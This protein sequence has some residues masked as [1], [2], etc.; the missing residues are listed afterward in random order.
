MLD[1]SAVLDEVLAVVA[2]EGLDDLRAS[3]RHAQALAAFAAGD[4]A[5]A[6][7][8]VRAALAMIDALRDESEPFFECVTLGAPILAE[9]RDGRL[10]PVFEDTVLRFRRLPAATATVCGLVNVADRAL[11]RR[12]A[13]ARAALDDALE[14]ARYA[15][16]VEMEATGASVSATGRAAR[17]TAMQRARGSNRRTRPAPAW[18]TSARRR[19]CCS[20]SPARRR[21]GR[22]DTARTDHAVFAT[23]SPSPTTRQASA[24]RCSRGG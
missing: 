7:Q 13:A 16:D 1:T 11:E 17:E 5:T 14:R 19:W 2:R 10:R 23:A 3:A 21:R 22:L 9:G 4:Y 12:P 8:H 15:G 20:I 6:R 24:V 18:A